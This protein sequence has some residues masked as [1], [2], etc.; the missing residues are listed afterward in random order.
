[1]II[2]AVNLSTEANDLEDGDPTTGPNFP[3][4]PSPN[5]KSREL[6]AALDLV[7]ALYANPP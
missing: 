1:M 4:R 2:R 7:Y 6:S 3:S 5:F